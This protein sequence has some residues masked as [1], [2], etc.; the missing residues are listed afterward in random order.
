MMQPS[1]LFTASLTPNRP[2]TPR[3]LRIVVAVTAALA[4]IPGLVFLAMGAWPVV[5]LM[6]LDVLALWWALSAA[7]RRAT[8]S[9]EVTL[10]PDRLEIRRIAEGGRVWQTRFDPFSVRLVVDRD[11][12]KRVHRVGLRS[13]DRSVE[14]ARFLGA[15]DKASFA[16][17]LDV[18][19]Y[20]AR[21]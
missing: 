12:A 1:P 20:R 6:G 3:G 11:A 21:N 13:R 16:R 17:A 5:G 2:L 9:E 19:L 18:A 8:A 7:A 14:I 10:W 15:D 4:A